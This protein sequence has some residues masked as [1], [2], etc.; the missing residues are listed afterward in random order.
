MTRTDARALACAAGLLVGVAAADDARAAPG[1]TERCE[2]ALPR[3]TVEDLAARM[4]A[5]H[6]EG[7]CALLRMNT[8]M[9]QTRVEWGLA[10]ARYTV[11]L[12]PRDC[13][14]EPSYKGESLDIYA[15]P[16]L[17]VACPAVGPA[18]QEFAGAER[19]E[20]VPVVRTT[21]AEVR[22]A[23]SALAP[24]NVA[25]AAWLAALVLS[26]LTAL[27]RLRA[28]GL[29]GLLSSIRARPWWFGGLATLLLF[30]LALRFSLPA[31]PSNWYGAFL[32]HAGPGDP[33]F[34]ASAIALQALAR[35]LGPWSDELAFGLVRVTGAL[36]VPLVAL[37]V[38][39]LGGPRS[40]A[41][42]AGFLVAVSPI[43]AR[44]SAS[45]A[46]HVLAGTC[47]LAAW[48]LWVRGAGAC[49]SSAA[50]RRLAQLLPRILALT[51]AL[52]AVL[53]R[54][55]CWP[56]LALLPLWTVLVARGDTTRARRARA[57]DA[58]VYW[59]LWALLGAY[60]WWFIVVPSNHPPPELAGVRATAAVLLSQFWYAATTPPYWI[61][62]LC[63]SLTSLGVVAMLI[64][65]RLGTLAATALSVALIF[66]P[67]GRNLTH[68]GLTGARYFVLLVPLLAVVAAQAV[69]VL[70]TWLAER[71]A[72]V[73]LPA[74]VLGVVAIALLGILSARPGW[75]HEYN[76]QAEYRFLAQQLETL[77]ARGRLEGCTLWYV[78]PRQP[79][80]EPDLDCCLDPARS[81]LTLVAPDLTFTSISS[82]PTPEPGACQLYYRGTLCELD[83]ALAPRV[84][85]GVARIKRQCAQLDQR[86][87]D[88]PVTTQTIEA[89]GLN[90]R[91]RGAPVV[92]LRGPTR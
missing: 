15:P 7:P 27:T 3:E 74:H 66:I 26:L 68:D 44:L 32:P 58:L 11:L 45:S 89:P 72:R 75:R 48:T 59:G 76:F 55:D 70:D 18:L 36:A 34:G 90:T 81:P 39:G 65:R 31:T 10:D 77:H 1:F 86:A 50:P 16:E 33:R 30:A 37:L 85:K 35:A 47:A 24:W 14:A 84:V 79:T 19:Q 41:L 23:P 21:V 42:V 69:E 40:A 87:R 28:R 80:G 91:Y 9:H 46:E 49:E 54:V 4:R 38:R 60:A 6:A 17:A 64:T 92:E 62:P 67:L 82:D 5:L 52:L 71:D 22:D 88:L 63:L 25:V 61:S 43:A 57:L 20:L 53:A 29:T 13:V 78:R 12:A 51:F 83:P 73:R 56:Q 2:H 8:S